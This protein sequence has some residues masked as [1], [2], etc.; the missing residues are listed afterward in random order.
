MPRDGNLGPVWPNIPNSTAAWSS[1]TPNAQEWQTRIH[2]CT[3]L[4]I[5]FSCW[6][7]N[8]S[9][10]KNFWSCYWEEIPWIM[11]TK[12]YWTFDI[13]LLRL[14]AWTV[15]QGSIFTFVTSLH[16]SYLLDILHFAFFTEKSS[17]EKQYLN[18]WKKP[19]YLKLNLR[20]KWNFSDTHHHQSGLVV[21][22]RER[23]DVCTPDIS[24]V[25]ETYCNNHDW[26]NCKIEVL[27]HSITQFHIWNCCF[28]LN[29]WRLLRYIATPL[30]SQMSLKPTVTTLIDIIVK[31]NLV[32]HRGFSLKKK[33]KTDR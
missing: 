32:K 8:I 27:I 24:N 23:G 19:L 18:M 26:Y 13:L 14:E 7:E 30:I 25:I 5:C 15:T 3:A 11:I 1:V 29:A 4:Q 2:I 9:Q 20:L 10:K 17:V 6:C 16:N 12:L 33:K 22:D 21:S 31:L 28:Q